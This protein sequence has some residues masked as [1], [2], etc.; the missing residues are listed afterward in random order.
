MNDNDADNVDAI[1][2]DTFFDKTNFLTI[3]K[4]LA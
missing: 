4:T 3:T 1:L 2:T